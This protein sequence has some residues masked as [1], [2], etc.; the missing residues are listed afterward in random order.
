VPPVR[1]EVGQVA[2]G[3]HGDHPG[4]RLG[5]RGGQRSNSRV[6][7]R[8]AEY[9]RVQQARQAQVAHELGFTP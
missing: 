6:R 5:R 3:E 2:A 4:Q 8:T 1:I 7:E 9:L